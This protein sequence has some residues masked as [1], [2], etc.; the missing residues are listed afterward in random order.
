MTVL[1]G[2]GAIAEWQSLPGVGHFP[3]AEMEAASRTFLEK[4]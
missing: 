4:Q 2:A 3:T 1:R